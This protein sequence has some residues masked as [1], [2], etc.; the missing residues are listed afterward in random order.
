MRFV[1][2]YLIGLTF[3]TGIMISGMANPAKVQN[4]FD[5]AGIWDPSLAMVMGGALITAL[6]GYRLVFGFRMPLFDRSFHLP[7]RGRVDG[8]LIFGSAVFGLGWGI[9]GF[10]PGAAIPAIGTGRVEV[11]AFVPAMIT[12]IFLARTVQQMAA[13][14]AF[15]LTARPCRS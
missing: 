9:A 4:F 11:L 2:T 8:R 15:S 12:G 10:C 3:G 14:G 1:T 5:F 6:L 13:E 7:A